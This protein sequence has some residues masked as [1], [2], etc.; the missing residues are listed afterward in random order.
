MGTEAVDSTDLPIATKMT[1]PKEYFI[2][3]LTG[4]GIKIDPIAFNNPRSPV[5]CVAL[6]Y[7]TEDELPQMYDKELLS[8]FY[9]GSM[10]EVR[11]RVVGEKSSRVANAQNANGETVLMKVCRRAL[12][13]TSKGGGLSVV[14][15][16]LKS[17][18]NPMVCCDSGKNVLHDVFWTA[19][20]PPAAVL[21]AMEKMV[22]ILREATGKNGLLELMLSE[23]KHGYTPLD[24]VVPSQ[25]PNWR[26]IVDTVVGWAAEEALLNSPAINSVQGGA[27]A[28]LST[29][30]TAVAGDAQEEEDAS[31]TATRDEPRASA[32]A[33]TSLP[34]R[35]LETTPGRLKLELETCDQNFASTVV[36]DMFDDDK[37]LVAQLCAHKSSFLISDVHDPDAAIVA[38]SPAFARETGYDP[39][40]V[41][42]RNCRFLQGPGTSSEQVNLIRRALATTSS[43]RVSL[44]NYKKSGET[45]INNFLLTPLR[46]KNGEVCYYV[47]V[48]NCAPDVANSRRRRLA[49]AGRTWLDDEVDDDDDDDDDDVADAG[50]AAADVPPERP[51]G[52]IV[53]S[54]SAETVFCPVDERTAGPPTTQFSDFDDNTASKRT[55]FAERGNPRRDDQVKSSGPESPHNLEPQVKKTRVSTCVIS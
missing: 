30:A 2:Q 55:L 19:K 43:V 35:A 52:R 37:R 46:H 54:Q 34:A 22:D 21:E 48:Q 8:V 24:Y 53:H 16:L 23:D 13:G 11:S 17:G 1:S 18:A 47:G 51:S 15:L 25:Q 39:E 38:V 6:K 29:F 42:G 5:A 26:K 31:A 4:R 33:P 20:P 49:A 36:N 12:S 14:S 40:D 9:E 32:D 45:F 44:L 7:R 10:E 27:A 41:L 3:Q 28:L 50:L